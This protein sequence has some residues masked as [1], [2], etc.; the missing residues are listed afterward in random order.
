MSKGVSANILRNYGAI[1]CS[2]SVEEIENFLY[3]IVYKGLK[4]SINEKYAKTFDASVVSGCFDTFLT[5]V[6]KI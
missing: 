6:T 2:H 5:Q 4:C 1:V 3:L